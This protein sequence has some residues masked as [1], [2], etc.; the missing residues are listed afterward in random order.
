MESPLAAIEPSISRFAQQHPGSQVWIAARNLDSGA[1]YG[2]AAHEQVRTA[3]TIKLPIL[4]AVYQAAATGKLRMEETVPLNADDKVAGS[5]V[6]RELADGTRLSI[7]DLGHVMI[8]ISDN[9]ATNLILDRIS[10]DYVNECLEQWGFVATRSMRKILGDGKN[11]KPN[12]SGHS[13]QGL[14]AVNKRFGIGSS[15][16]REMVRLLEMLE[17]GQIVSA[18]ASQEI[19]ATLKRQQYKDGIG[20]RIEAQ[21]PVASKSGSL[22]ALRSD[23]G[24]VYSPKGR[25]A[26]A[27]TVDGL[28][29]IDYSPDNPGNILIADLTALLLAGL[30]R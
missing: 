22:D 26:I 29:N 2:R 28:P 12:P 15:S 18:A 14:L 10:A 24:L 25:L 5:G 20:R 27:I 1:E 11:L 19:I 7:R 13:Q 9:T 3:S 30:T 6:I 8:V 21:M 4:C 16:P 17:R 23:V